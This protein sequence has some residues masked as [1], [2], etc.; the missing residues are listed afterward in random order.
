MKCRLKLKLHKLW[1]IA[2]WLST[3]WQH[4]LF[5]KIIWVFWLE[6]VFPS[7]V[8]AFELDC[9]VI[10]TLWSGKAMIS[11]LHV[12]LISCRVGF[13]L[14][15][16]YKSNFSCSLSWRERYSR[17]IASTCQIQLA[18]DSKTSWPFKIDSKHFTWSSLKLSDGKL[19]LLRVLR[20]NPT[21]QSTDK[22]S[23]LPAISDVLFI[24][25]DRMLI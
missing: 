21:R 9:F 16:F 23:G 8:T 17:E 4:S 18:E 22:N 20:E 15:C 2:L 6:R 25:C 3:L 19:P 7:L 13:V 14:S 12:N 24:V 1:R 10:A 11:V 5:V